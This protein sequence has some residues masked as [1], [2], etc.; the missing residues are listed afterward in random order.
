METNRETEFRKIASLKF[1]YEI[2][3]DGRLIRN[4]KSKKYH[5][6]HTDKDGYNVVW[7]TFE[8]KRRIYRVARLVA[9]AWI[10]QAPAG[11]EVDHINRNRR[12]DDFG[13]LRW[14]THQTNANNRDH[15]P[16][17][18]ANKLRLGNKVTVNNKQFESFTDAAKFISSE[19]NT[20]FN[21]IRYYLKKRRHYIHGFTIKYE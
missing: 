17:A 5:L 12:D 21:T 15:E 16:M 14:A 11:Y 10:G 19:T 20:S 1:L 8:G 2:S 18:A 13:N 7:L 9:E 6:T 4:I 3:R